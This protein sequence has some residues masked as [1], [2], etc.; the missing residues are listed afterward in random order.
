MIQYWY[1]KIG[2]S[3]LDTASWNN[4][5]SWLLFRN[6]L[7]P[8]IKSLLSLF[9][10]FLSSKWLEKDYQC[11]EA[12]K[13]P[14]QSFFLSCDAS[15]S[16]TFC[17]L[18]DSFWY[19]ISNHTYDGQVCILWCTV[20]TWELERILATSNSS[21]AN[22]VMISFFFFANPIFFPSRAVWNDSHAFTTFFRFCYQIWLMLKMMNHLLKLRLTFLSHFTILNHSDWGVTVIPIDLAFYIIAG[23]WVSSGPRSGL[24]LII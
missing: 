24:V 8:S 22:S 4:T 10:C 21:T 5:L 15:N 1:L 19:F 2:C 20:T 9:I 16:I 14:V 7:S 23:G 6:V 3:F 12:H 11:Y 13:R 17:F 18:S